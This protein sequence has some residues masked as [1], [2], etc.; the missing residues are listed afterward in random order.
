MDST[1]HS[2]SDLHAARGLRLLAT[3]LALALLWGCA[4]LSG[5]PDQ[6]APLRLPASTDPEIS[7]RDL[8]AY[9]A[10]LTDPRTEGRHSG[11]AGEARAADYL[12]RAM[13]AIG[14]DAAGDGGGYPHRFEFTAGISTGSGNR[15]ELSSTASPGSNARAATSAQGGDDD[16]PRSFAVDRDWR[17]LAFSKVGTIAASPIVFAGYGLVTPASNDFGAIDAYAELDV[18]DRWVMVLRDLPQSLEGETRQHLQRYASLRHKAMIARDQGARG[19]LFVSGP[20]GRFRDELVPLRFDAALAGTR[21]AALSLGD[22]AADAILQA[23]GRALATL[24]EELEA[25]LLT[26]GFEIQRALLAA[27]VDLVMERSEG[28]NVIGRLQVGN[29]PSEETIVLGAHFDHLGRGRGGNSLAGADEIGEIHPGA[30]DNASGVAVLLEIAEAFVEGRARGEDLGRRDFVFAAWSGEELG[31]LGSNAWVSDFVNPHDDAKGPIAYL[32]FD[33]VG[34]LRKQ[35]VVQGLGSSDTWPGLLEDASVGLDLAIFSQDDSYL[36]TD[37]T[38]FY[39]QGIPI[40]SAFSGVHSEYHTP[41]DRAELLDLDG[42]AQIARLFE[43]IAISLSRATEPPIHRA[44]QGPSSAA[45]R[46]GFRV[47]LGTIPD[48]A[49][50]DVRGVQ[51][52]SVAPEGPAEQAGLRGGDVI[53]EVDGRVIENLYDYT[54]ALEALRVA[55]PARVVVERDGVRLDFEV[56]PAS[57]E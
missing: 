15:L 10:A 18:R 7:P 51:L 38:S 30:D 13:G 3:G 46:A 6:T 43:R 40:L 44:Q 37:A 24:Q 11:S 57:R 2:R 50:T 17:P 36:P 29:A 53:V 22:G 49:R 27:Q 41:R 12:A 20:L 33:M 55:E 56:L 47:F 9:V 45:P 39:T 31:L 4:G 26:P 19:V 52:S 28:T 8:E 14:L 1:R 54:Y 5:V 34:R 32:N 21:I 42:A 35:L 25:D 23:G 16:A 48:Y